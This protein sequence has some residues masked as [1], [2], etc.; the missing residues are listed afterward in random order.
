MIRGNVNMRV[1]HL[2]GIRGVGAV[3][4]VLYHTCINSMFPFTDQYIQIANKIFLLQGPLWVSV[5]FVVSGFALAYN[6][7]SNTGRIVAYRLLL[8]RYVRLTIPISVVYLLMICCWHAGWV[9]PVEARPLEWRGYLT[10]APAPREVVLFVLW[11]VYFNYSFSSILG[12]LWSMQ[13]ELIGSIT[14]LIV[15]IMFRRPLTRGIVFGFLGLYVYSN[16]L[17]YL[18][19]CMMVGC[20]FAEIYYRK[21]LRDQFFLP[22]ILLIITIYN[23]SEYFEMTKNEQFFNLLLFSMGLIFFYPVKMLFASHLFQGLGSVSYVMY[24]SHPIILWVLIWPLINNMNNLIDYRFYNI[25][26]FA[27]NLLSIILCL[28]LAK[29]LSGVDKLSIVCSR[30]FAVNVM[31]Y[32]SRKMT[33]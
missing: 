33:M 8:G 17:D 23:F 6:C 3:A 29:L 24:L 15:Y 14:I 18:Y 22:G 7:I 21:L 20:L 30:I 31:K 13:Y 26:L 11:N 16:S 1:A 27:V 9:M 25:S 28:I 5:F 32:T 10:A 19:Y 2:N 4:V 12:P